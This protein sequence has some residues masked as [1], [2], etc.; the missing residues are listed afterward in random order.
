MLSDHRKLIEV[1]EEWG[2]APEIVETLFWWIGASPKLK[3]FCAV[4]RTLQD[5]LELGPEIIEPIDQEYLGPLLSLLV[6]INAGSQRL[7]DAIGIHLVDRGTKGDSLAGNYY[8]SH[9][10]YSLLAWSLAQAKEGAR[11][12]G[13]LRIFQL[14]NFLAYRKLVIDSTNRQDY[15][16]SGGE[17]LGLGKLIYSVSNACRLIRE[18]FRIGLPG[19]VVFLNPMVPHRTFVDRVLINRHFKGVGHCSEYEQ[20]VGLLFYKAYADSTTISRNVETRL[21]SIGGSQWYTRENIVSPYT[22]DEATAI[23]DADDTDGYWG[24]SH[25]LQ[26]FEG[27]EESLREWDDCDLAPEE[28]TADELLMF[29]DFGCRHEEGTAF[30]RTMAALG[31]QKAIVMSN[32]LLP[33]AWGQMTLW[34]LGCLM[35]FCGKLHRHLMQVVRK[36]PK[37]KQLMDGVCLIMLMLWFGRTLEEV[38]QLAIIPTDKVRQLSLE[39][40]GTI[41]P[42]VSLAYIA[43]SGEWRIRAELPA[44]KK[45]ISHEAAALCHPQIQHIYLPDSFN[46]SSFLRTIRPEIETLEQITFPF[47]ALSAKKLRKTLREIFAALPEPTRYT[48]AKLTQFLFHQMVQK[49]NG[50][51]AFATSLTG[52]Y[53]RLSSVQLHYMTP[54]ADRLREIYDQVVGDFIESVYS[55]FYD[56][57]AP[58]LLAHSSLP[59]IYLGYLPCPTK[60]SVQ[61]LV[62]RLK[63]GIQ[64]AKTGSDEELRRSHNQYS[65]YTAL[66]FGWATGYRAVKSPF[67]TLEHI[68]ADSGI[69]YISD[70]EG[71]D[72]YSTRPVWVPPT[73]IQQL[74]YYAKHVFKLLP[75]ILGRHP[76]F[77]SDPLRHQVF[78]LDEDWQPVQVRPRTISEQ[79]HD[80]F[81]LPVNINRRFLRSGLAEQGVSGEMINGFMGHWSIGEEP[82]GKYS[83]LCLQDYVRVVSGSVSRLF[84]ELGWTAIR[85]PQV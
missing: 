83:S 26:R 82:W 77:A 32:Q 21:H 30:S 29:A 20:L 11:D 37:Q 51:L 2:F 4:A 15:L 81:P 45:P 50:D 33:N 78:F 73:V 44:Y 47:K 58:M 49:S 56:K 53:H 46:L 71:E 80:I 63:A 10:L 55:T 59:G 38:L 28:N 17:E 65:L 16:Q 84:G 62:A 74:R 75:R 31:Q 36:S 12:I 7:V 9:P 72:F 70:K 39:Q 60:S 14:H 22:F 42:G 18:Y 79:L 41:S 34:E 54:L 5:I 8:S 85:A 69:G 68:D 3:A 64:R 40:L 1:T 13:T 23:G 35:R 25:T 76:E 24:H 27:T 43:A 66:M 19:D 61:D 52:R 48:E 67:L 6:R 57:P